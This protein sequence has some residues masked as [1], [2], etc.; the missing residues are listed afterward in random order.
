MFFHLSPRKDLLRGANN[1]SFAEDV[2]SFP[3]AGDR[4]LKVDSPGMGT[5]HGAKDF[6][7]LNPGRALLK[8]IGEFA[9]KC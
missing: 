8:L 9:A 6:N 7:L 5:Q 2:D 1:L 3:H 4:I